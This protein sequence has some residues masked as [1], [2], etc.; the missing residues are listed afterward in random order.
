M[1]HKLADKV[2]ID[3]PPP[4]RIDDLRVFRS[5][6]T[7]QAARPSKMA[8]A[9]RPGSEKDPYIVDARW[10]GSV[11]TSWTLSR[12]VDD[13]HDD[14]ADDHQGEHE[15]KA[16]EK[17]TMCSLVKKNAQIWSPRSTRRPGL[18]EMH[19]VLLGEKKCANLVT[20]EHT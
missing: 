11:R 4:T 15:D 6:L 7:S 10:G 5:I 8:C 16:W 1:L 3:P 2:R 13:A 12:H 14:D 17:C 18:E 20:K 9:S 19:I